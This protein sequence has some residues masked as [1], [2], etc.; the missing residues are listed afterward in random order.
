M[1]KSELLEL[2]DKMKSIRGVT[3]YK[4]EIFDAI[5][6]LNLKLRPTQCASCIRD[7][8][9]IILDEIEE[10]LNDFKE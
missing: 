2:K 1:D 6:K 8:L 3:K 7:Y 4:K 5:K 9:E 10:R